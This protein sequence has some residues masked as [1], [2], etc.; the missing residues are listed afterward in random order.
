VSS[1]VTVDRLQFTLTVTYHYLFPILTM[2]LALFIAYF[3]TV[4]H[5]G[6]EDRRFPRLRK[7]AEERATAEAAAGFWTKIFAVNCQLSEGGW[8]S[9]DS[10]TQIRERAS[11]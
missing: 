9:T 1:E 5:L 11:R 2:G 7:I 8:A 6:R 10:E 4:S 3:K